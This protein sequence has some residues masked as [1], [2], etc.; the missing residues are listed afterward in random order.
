MLPRYDDLK[1]QHY[2]TNL[3]ALIAEHAR[4]KPS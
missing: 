4:T 3:K 1:H 2:R